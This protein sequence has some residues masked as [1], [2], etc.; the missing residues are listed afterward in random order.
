MSNRHRVLLSAALGAVLALP[1]ASLVRVSS[2]PPQEPQLKESDLRDLSEALADYIQARIENKD[3]MKTE[4]EVRQALDKVSKK[5][6][7][8]DPLASPADLGLALWSSY[9][10]AKS[11]APKGKVDT[12]EADAIGTEFEYAVWAPSK[13][14]ARNG[15]Y[16]LVLCIPDQGESPK[17]HLTER[18]A[19]AEFRDNAI[20]A[21][22]PMPEDPALW[23][24]AGDRTKPGG[25]AYVLTALK[26]VSEAYAIDFDRIYLC[27]R[28]AGVAAAVSI[29]GQFPD[30][31]AGVLGR[32]GDAGEAAPENF[33]NLPTYFAGGG[34]QATALEEKITAL[35]YDNCTIDP[36]GKDEDLWRWMQENPR[37]SYPTKV[38]LVPGDP[39]PTRAYWIQVP[40]QE[41]SGHVEATI[42]R[43]SNTI[44]IEATGVSDVQLYFND[45]LVDLGQPV[46]VVCNGAEHVDEIPRSLKTMLDLVFNARSDPGKIFV[47]RKTYHLP[48]RGDSE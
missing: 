30:R 29:A 41:G 38:T 23:G 34:G 16:P 28:G 7:G 42:D 6:K 46:H 10:Y 24:V 43:D 32:A 35:G 18:W 14:S 15:P 47:A 40:P 9:D 1:A 33:R 21:A 25:V 36:E 45:R 17:Q 20:L 27:G 22:P 37:N 2:G 19:A 4:D 13:Y 11:R 44:T 26:S 8:A 48:E 12:I 3:V 31:F 39:Y 5:L